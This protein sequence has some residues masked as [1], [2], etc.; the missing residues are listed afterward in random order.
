MTTAT[1]PINTN[2]WMTRRIL[3]EG[4]QPPIKKTVAAIP[5]VPTTPPSVYKI[6]R[7]A[8]Y[9][10]D[11]T[12]PIQPGRKI[13]PKGMFRSDAPKQTAT[14][15]YSQ[16]RLG[17]TV[18]IAAQQSKG[19]AT[20]KAT[21]GVTYVDVGAPRMT[22]YGHTVLTHRCSRTAATSAVRA[23]TGSACVETAAS[24]R[25]ST[26]SATASWRPSASRGWPPSTN[27]SMRSACD[28]PPRRPRRR[29]RDRGH[30]HAHH[31]ASR[32][33]CCRRPRPRSGRT[34]GR[35]RPGRGKASRATRCSARREAVGQAVRDDAARG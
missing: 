29:R 32:A 14:S 12:S 20:P 11:K 17:L 10:P 18:F 8:S 34:P 19:A 26:R 22:R 16:S 5:S 2:V 21:D 7:T 9:S 13:S 27:R 15:R 3:K 25:S 35:D 6:G 1:S 24:A 30:R 4:R 23:P 28:S 33:P 31:E